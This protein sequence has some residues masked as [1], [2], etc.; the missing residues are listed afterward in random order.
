VQEIEV[1]LVEERRID[2]IKCADEEERVSVGRRPND[3]LGG[4]VAGAAW[5]V[6]DDELLAETLRQPLTDQASRYVGCAAGGKADDDAPRPRRIG[7]PCVATTR[8]GARRRPLPD[9][10]IAF[11]EVSWRSPF[12]MPSIPLR[13]ENRLQMFAQSIL[14]LL[15]AAN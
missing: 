15:F 3:R 7:R 8:P 5:P 11:A 4:D 1:E 14:N 10:E 2:R 9:T 12:A 6:V 13:T